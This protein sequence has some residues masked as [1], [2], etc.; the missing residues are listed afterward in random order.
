MWWTVC[1]LF[2]DGTAHVRSPVHT[3]ALLVCKPFGSH[4]KLLKIFAKENTIKVNIEIYSFRITFRSE[5]EKSN[6]ILLNQECGSFPESVY[7]HPQHSLC[8][9]TRAFHLT[10]WN[11]STVREGAFYSK[12]NV[13]LE[14]FICIISL[15]VENYNIRYPACIHSERGGTLNLKCDFKIEFHVS[16]NLLLHNCI[17]KWRLQF[18]KLDP[19]STARGRASN[20][21]SDFKMKFYAS[22]THVWNLNVVKWNVQ[23]CC[24]SIA[25]YS[26]VHLSP[27]VRMYIKLGT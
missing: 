11:V 1:E 26:I 3:N 21:K 23:F 7:F 17:R 4:D 2:A 27:Y 5:K 13:H 25:I 10:I 16:K 14:N 8:E 20:P 22:K 12:S 18:W 19:V 9:H 24:P 15:E 6:E